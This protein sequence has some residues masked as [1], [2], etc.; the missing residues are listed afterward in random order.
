MCRDDHRFLP[1]LWST[2]LSKTAGIEYHESVAF[3]HPLAY[4]SGSASSH[5]ETTETLVVDCLD[6]IIQRQV[7]K[8]VH[9]HL[10]VQRHDNKI[11]PE[12]HSTDSTPEGQLCNNTALSV[13]PQ[14]NLVW[15]KTRLVSTASKSEDICSEEHSN[16]A[17]AAAVVKVPAVRQTEG[18]GAVHPKSSLRTTNKACAIL[19]EADVQ[20]LI[21]RIGL[22]VHSCNST[23]DFFEVVR[24]R[25]RLAPLT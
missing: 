19:I 11:S 22:Q 17:Q 6:R 16:D 1:C 23:P 10:A 2:R 24:Q 20:K 5:G 12:T 15:L 9:V 18:V 3:L 4:Q 14:N 21:D 7:S 13:I 8:T 25:P